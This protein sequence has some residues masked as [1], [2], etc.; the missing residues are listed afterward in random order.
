VS[1]GNP[2]HHPRYPLSNKYDADW[3]FENLMGPNALWLMESLTEVL[4]I[5][6]GMNVL[7]LGCGRAMTSIFLAKEFGAQVWAAD[8]WIDPDD[9][10]KRI[11]AAGMEDMVTPVYAEAHALPFEYNFFDA[12]VSVDAYHYFG[13]SDLYIGYLTDFLYDE[14]KVGIVVPSLHEELGDDV[15]DALAPF[16]NWD[17]C[18]FHTAEWWRRH[19]AKTGKVRVNVAG[20][21]EDGWADWLHFDEVTAQHTDG[22]RHDG[23]LHSAAM[24][25]ADGGHNLCFTRMVGT[26]RDKPQHSEPTGR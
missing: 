17:F 19:W 10:A 1:G 5:G 2:L 13:T 18:S 14:G 11:A 15:P 3:V 23:A 6:P 20:E 24:L 21:T 22:W 16:W 7:D 8:L 26:K 25:R 9:N 4:A 12:I